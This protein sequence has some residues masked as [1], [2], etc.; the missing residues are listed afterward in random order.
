MATQDQPVSPTLQNSPAASDNNVVAENAENTVAVENGGNNVAAENADNEVII[1]EMSPEPLMSNP[2]SGSTPS[3]PQVASVVPEA[4]EKSKATPG[5]PAKEKDLGPPKKAK[6]TIPDKAS[7]DPVQKQPVEVVA[8][9]DTKESEDPAAEIPLTPKKL[10]SLLDEA[11]DFCQAAQDFW[12]KGELENALEAL[13]QAYSLILKVDS[14]DIKPELIQQKED[15]RLIISRRIL[16]IYASRNIIANGNHNAIPLVVNRYIQAE[17]DLF[18]TGREKNFFIDS[19]RRSG[20][21]RDYIVAELRKAGLPEELSWLPLIESGFK[22]NALSRARALG[23]WQFIPSTGFK[24]G[25]KR[26]VFIDERLDYEKSTQAAIAYLRELHQ[27]FGD[28]TTALAAYNCGEGRVLRVIRTQNVNYLDDFWDLFQRLPFETARYVPRFLATLY[29]LN[30]KERFG[31]DAV[32]VDPPIEFE[33][34]TV[35]KQIH[36]RDIANTIGIDLAKLTDLNPELRYKILPRELYQLRVPIGKAEE[37]LAK[38]DDIPVSSRP[39]PA[40]VNHRVRSG[41]A[42]STIARK[43]RTSVN[44][45]AR[46]NN[47][48][49]NNFIVAGQVLKIPQGRSYQPPAQI[50]VPEKPPATHRVRSGDSLWIIAKRYGTTTKEIQ[51]LNKLNSTTLSI[52]QTLLISGQREEASAK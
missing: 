6:S 8:A 36:L 40:Y 34:A 41:E 43:Y 4:A 28:W 37:L 51:E 14:P 12:Q 18:T 47:I 15:L 44:S 32:T 26:D 3:A 50:I 9:D 10:Q 25:L 24:F 2:S 39:Q 21:Y 13:D 17:I 22:V 16:E 42:L 27:I 11:L 5:A 33:I 46:A 52:G 20:R 29:V 48:H 7:A 45:I 19:Y 1:E 30:N 38:L 31:L 35:T 49:R 23:L